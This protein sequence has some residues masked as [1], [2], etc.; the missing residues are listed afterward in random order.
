MEIHGRGK[1]SKELNIVALIPE[2][3]G[4]EAQKDFQPITSVGCV[5]NLLTKMV[6]NR[7]RDTMS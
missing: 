1:M 4:L 6:L 3:K 5:Y 2:G 7:M